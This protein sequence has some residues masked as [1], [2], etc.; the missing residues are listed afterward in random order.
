MYRRIEGLAKATRAARGENEFAKAPRVTG[1]ITACWAGDLCEPCEKV[2][3][4]GRRRT[5]FS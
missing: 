4:D 2:R 5:G 1:I 3:C